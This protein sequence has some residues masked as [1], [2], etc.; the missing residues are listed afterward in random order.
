M[1]E[2]TF[3]GQVYVSSKR[4]AQITGYAKDYI[5]QLCRE[6]RVIARLVGRNWY[7]L[8]PSIREHRFG[9]AEEKVLEAPEAEEVLEP[10]IPEPEEKSETDNSWQA[11]SYSVD[12]SPELLPSLIHPV[13]GTESEP[14]VETFGVGDKVSIEQK[15]TTS[16]LNSSV[17]NEMQSAW[18]D[19]FAR[20][21]E[22][23]VA[24][25]TLLEEH[26]SEHSKSS[27]HY[28]EQE[29][30]LEN[31]SEP[32]SLEKVSEV[33]E[34]LHQ[35]EDTVPIKRTY[36]DTQEYA[37]PS[38]N[39]EDFNSQ[40]QPSKTQEEGVIIRERKI[41]RRKKSSWA[42]KTVLILIAIGAVIATAL[43]SGILESYLM[44]NPNLHSR[45]SIL[46]G[47]MVIK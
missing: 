23:N 38:R 12:P 32:V 34:K 21:N 40:Y 17:V 31:D 19:W 3:D 7:V 5:G 39:R 26:D 22:L 9:I 16:P 30:G 6:G 10:K 44:K 36:R 29:N 11:A 46:M 35:N 25:E 2:L 20:T 18:H 14:G 37:I 24:N 13:T 33:V 8:E 41:I 1:D 27:N 42:L 47:E 15:P 45:F 43:G 4:A 28:L